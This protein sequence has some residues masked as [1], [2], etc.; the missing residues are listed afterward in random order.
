MLKLVFRSLPA[1]IISLLILPVLVFG[2]Q[3]EE[4]CRLFVNRAFREIGENC[5]NMDEGEACYAYG[6]SGEVASTFY[7]DGQP[8]VILDNVFDNPSE[9]VLILNDEQSETLESMENEKFILDTNDNQLEENQW[10]VSFQ[11]VRGNLPRQLEPD[12]AVYILFGGAR[13][14]NGI[15]PEDALVLPQNPV[16][17]IARAETIVYGSPVGLG[18]LVPDDA[19]GTVTGAVEADGISADGNWVRIFHVYQRKFGQR[20]TA[21][22]QVADL[23]AP[24]RIETLPL[25]DPETYTAMQRLFLSNIFEQPVCENVTPPGLVVQGPESFEFDFTINN[26]PSRAIGSA[27]YEQIAPRRMRIT[28]L[29]GFTILWPDSGNEVVIPAGFFRVVCL[30]P[31]LDLGIDSQQNDRELDNDC[32]EGGTSALSGDELGALQGFTALPDSI[33]IDPITE[34]PEE[35]CPSGVGDPNCTLQ[36]Q[37]RTL[38]QVQVQCDDGTITLDVCQQYGLIDATTGQ[39]IVTF[40]DAILDAS[41]QTDSDD[42]ST[43]DEPPNNNATV[44]PDD[45]D[46]PPNDDA[47]ATPGDE[48]DDDGEQDDVTTTPDDEQ[49]DD[50]DEQDD[51]DD[52]DGN[53]GNDKDVGNAGE[54]P[55]GQNP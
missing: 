43:T 24:A 12:E 25:I 50:D 46:E 10:G 47:T 54:D 3:T 21:W 22:V 9:S 44:T 42:T 14:E 23:E 16:A 18:Y 28:T 31:L 37:S 15:Y 33:L 11:L 1:I 6:D 41:N 52:E 35:V 36:V 53:P 40:A 49:D 4:L 29:S 30:T 7:I 5:S 2:Q 48:P 55:S 17:L 19:V 34:V 39:D 8:R 20:A 45:T 51:D 32:G 38:L 27:Y 13:I 26:L